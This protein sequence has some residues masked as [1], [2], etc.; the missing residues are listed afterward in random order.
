M[1]SP[2]FEEPTERMCATPT[3]ARRPL[4]IAP[5]NRGRCPRILVAI[6]GLVAA[7]AA[8]SAQRNSGVTPTEGATPADV[9]RGGSTAA[10]VEA[11]TPAGP[12]TTFGDGKWEIGVDIAEGKYKTT[13]PASGS[14]CYADTE[15]DAGKIGQQEVAQ[16]PVTMTIKKSD[17]Y[18]KTSG[19]A[20]WKKQ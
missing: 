3:A 4:H 2:T 15:N 19:C 11:P 14:I 12:L 16:G 7:L 20:E 18:F 17:G 6:L 10:A 8:C 1:S 13:G 5:H 9:A